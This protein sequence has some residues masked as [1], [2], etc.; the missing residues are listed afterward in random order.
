MYI[1]HL[2]AIWASLS[3]AEFCAVGSGMAG[4]FGGGSINGSDR[5]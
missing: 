5:M 1:N 2:D 4:E 3:A